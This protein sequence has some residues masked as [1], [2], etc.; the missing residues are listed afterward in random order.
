MNRPGIATIPKAWR[1][2][3]FSAMSPPARSPWRCQRDGC[4]PYPQHARAQTL[5]EE[6]RNHGGPARRVAG[7]SYPY[8]R[9]CGEELVKFRVNA[10]ESVAML[11]STD[12]IRCFLSAPPV[13]R[14]GSGQREYQ[15]GPVNRRNQQAA[16]RVRKP[17]SCLI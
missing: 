12:I 1:Q 2:P 4:V 14:D 10:H 7:L 8:K 16:L 5:R 15:D 13:D 3:Q 11:H 9:A 6:R 17:Q